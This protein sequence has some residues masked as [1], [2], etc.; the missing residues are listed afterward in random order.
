MVLS[1][2]RDQVDPGLRLPALDGP[3]RPGGRRTDQAF[4]VKTI[5]LRIE[6]ATALRQSATVT[7][8]PADRGECREPG[9]L[10]LQRGM[11]G[12]KVALA[13]M[14]VTTGDYRL[15]ARLVVL[16]RCGFGLGV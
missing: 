8:W 16:L 14:G 12:R 5:R 1:L 13:G 4:D 15:R 11:A 10:T 9:P 3:Q 7:S 6:R 2:G